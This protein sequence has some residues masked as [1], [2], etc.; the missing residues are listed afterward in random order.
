[1]SV[2]APRLLTLA[3]IL[4]LGLSSLTASAAD[5]PP[6]PTAAPT[7]P[8][9]GTTTATNIVV[10]G[11]ARF[12][13]LSP[14]LVRLEYA[15]DGRFE[16][17]PTF[18]AV[19]RH[20]PLAVR[21][22]VDN[23]TLTITTGR[24]VLR[25]LVSSGPFT[26]DNLQIYLDV[27]AVPVIA[28]PSWSLPGSCEFRTACE[29]ETAE[30]RDGAEFATD[31]AGFTGRGYTA[32]RDR[33]D[34]R[35]GW[36]QHGIPS[37]GDHAV[38][39]RYSAAQPRTVVLT[40]G[41]QTV[42][43][44]LPAS[45]DWS[46][47]AATLPLPA[48][49]VPM[50]V[51]CKDSD[52]CGVNVDSVAVT[53]VGEPDPA[54]ADPAHAAANL[55]GWRRSL[56]NADGPRPL[57]EGLLSRDGWYLLNDTATAILKPDFTLDQRPA[58]AGSAYQDG[59]F[60]GYG[61]DYRQGLADLHDLTGPAVELPRWALGNWFSRYYPYSEA[62]YRDTILPAFRAN[63]VPLDAL[64]VDTD[65]KSPNQW[66]GWEWNPERFPDPQGFL[67]W[68]H[69]QG[70]RVSL[71]IHPSIALRDP[72]Y[73]EVRDALGH[74][75][76]TGGCPLPEL[77]G[78]F[79]LTDP[80]QA[81][82][83]FALHQPFED[84]GVDN[85]WADT[86]CDGSVAQAPGISPDSWINA[87]YARRA[88][89]R[90]Q[91][92]FSWNRTGSGY[93][94]YG[95]S[96]IFPAG[97]WADHRYSVDTSMDTVSTWS[98]L[99]FAAHYTVARGNIGIPF[100]SHDIGAHNYGGDGNRLP[101]D[102][103]ARWIQFGAFQPI[104]RLH[105]NHGYRLPW[106]Y[107][108]DAAAAGRK[109]MQLREALVPYLYTLARQAHDTGLPMC[110]GMYLNYPDQEN[111]YHADGQYLL[112]DDL[113][114]APVTTQ[115][116]RDVPTT[117]W[118]PPGTWVDYFTGERHIGPGTQTVRTDLQT[119]PVFL[120]A[121]GV[122]PTRTDEVD[123]A[124]QRP[125]DQVTLD[126]ATG[127]S[128]GFTLYEDSG[129]GHGAR[130]GESATTATTYAENGRGGTLTIAAR[131]GGFP[132]AAANRA[133]TVRFRDTGPPRSV[134]VNGVAAAEGS[135]TYDAASRTLTVRTGSLPAGTSATVAFGG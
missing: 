71:N 64:V 116:V 78:V 90:G 47:A 112:G 25:Y 52:Q 54:V 45:A 115:G 10:D 74:D 36:Q 57:Y 121:G 100:E 131:R 41:D 113:L 62:D 94:G 53:E 117:V 5:L 111:A 59:Y 134:R 13:V 123:Y 86:C 8:A 15:Q 87:L 49:D 126:V 40:A 35:I 29:A 89:Q 34:G 26:Q 67:D 107:P 73:Q 56:D 20:A 7:A 65:F 37:A 76:P 79:D 48:G 33:T 55:G 68:A 12:Q 88:D 91:R 72:R 39:L 103:Y 3:V 38:H 84:Q 23:G 44:D 105:S 82:A 17:R 24:M 98:L 95:E 133:W 109:F 58:R 69:D 21:T 125:L 81:E 6:P 99:A 27:G 66:N 28:R 132:D 127:G 130:N 80:A 32:L 42:D 61:H 110:R 9:A 51:R 104:L 2:T 97:P 22:S 19:S 31:Q 118:F 102:L 70:L 75:L 16:D 18:N 122:L 83:Y 93:T 1:M 120:R 14:T 43:V 108:P 124:D 85:W 101:D 46:T 60:F 50:S 135:W 106:D 11:R 4:T 92:G 63:H 129:E 114:V 119:M 30:L 128:G 96:A 77:C